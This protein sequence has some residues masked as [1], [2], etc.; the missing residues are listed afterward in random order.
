MP[1][2]GRWQ[3]AETS[4]VIRRSGSSE[5]RTTIVRLGNRVFTSSSTGRSR[6]ASDVSRSITRFAS[7]TRVT[8]GC[9][10]SGPPACSAAGPQSCWS[11]DSTS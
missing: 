5:P 4:A 2:S 8:C 7:T 6:S 11:V 3:R 10:T 1:G 9:S